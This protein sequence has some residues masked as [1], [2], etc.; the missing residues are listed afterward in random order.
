VDWFGF[1]AYDLYGPC[2]VNV[3]ALGAP[4]VRPHTDT[5]E[6][7]KGLLPIAFAEVNSYIMN[8][9]LSYYGEDTH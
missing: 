9:G 6:I 8:F 1:I 2:D 5:R 3:A 4:K 7:K